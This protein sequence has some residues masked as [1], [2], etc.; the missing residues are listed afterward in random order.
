VDRD[1]A[2]SQ[3]AGIDAALILAFIMNARLTALVMLHRRLSAPIAH[4][5]ALFSSSSL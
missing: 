2:D 4:Q 5:A 3:A 1:E